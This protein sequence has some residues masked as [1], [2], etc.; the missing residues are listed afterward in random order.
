LSLAFTF[1]QIAALAEE[2]GQPGGVLIDYLK[3]R[4]KVEQSP[5]WLPKG[6]LSAGFL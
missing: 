5:P 4:R 2:T 1:V 3:L 6:A